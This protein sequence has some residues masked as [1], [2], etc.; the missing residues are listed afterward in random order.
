M[1]R[2]SFDTAE[3]LVYDPVSSNRNATRASL[4]T[5]GF[6]RME[7]V[8][9]VDAFVESVRRRPPDLTLCEAQGTE[10][11]ICDTIQNLRQGVSTY[12]PFIVIIVT[13]WEQTS[14]LVTRVLNSGAD[15]LLLRPFSTTT[16]QARINSHIE[17]R[18]GFVV[19]TD[20]VG[21]DRRRVGDMRPSNV[22]IF[23]PPNSLR[24][25]AQERLTSEEATQ[26]LD[27]EL[28]TARDMLST[29]KLRRDAFQLCILWRLMSDKNPAGEDYAADLARLRDKARAISRR[30]MDTEFDQAIE[31]C[32]SVQAAIEGLEVGIDRNASMH[33]LGHAALNLSA[34]FTPEKTEQEHLEEVDATVTVIKARNAPKLAS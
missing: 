19:T 4:Y 11:E 1:S 32:E 29:E 3:V 12:N 25:K 5:I 31:W 24:M 16:L 18:K 13:A 20:Y 15:D 7:T 28:K 2:L 22:N 34:I 14:A 27:R 21:P 23:E 8:A 9:T 26:R 33:M 10:T 6:R 30:C 17:R